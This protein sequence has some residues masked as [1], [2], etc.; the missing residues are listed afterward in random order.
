MSV[1]YRSGSKTSTS[2]I[3]DYIYP[4]G[5]ACDKSFPPALTL[6]F[7]RSHTFIYVLPQ[8]ILSLSFRPG[9]AAQSNTVCL[10]YPTMKVSMAFMALA[11]IVVGVSG[12]AATKT[13]RRS[14]EQMM[15]DLIERQALREQKLEEMLS[16]RKAQLADHEAGRSLLSGDDHARVTKQVEA[17]GKKLK[18]M[19]EM[20]D[21]DRSEMLQR[22]MEM[23]DQ[24]NSRTG[25]H[26]RK[27]EL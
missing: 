9:I 22:E 8:P 26:R 20:T 18:T 21:R 15:T 24:I 6:C 13:R 1:S 25:A 23:M 4:R 19:K 2:C 14:R 12:E 27:M 10:N 11:A 16:E 5:P 17:F 3:H 7:A